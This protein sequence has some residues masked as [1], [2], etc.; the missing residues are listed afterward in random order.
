[1]R[2]RRWIAVLGFALCVWCLTAFGTTEVRAE[3]VG[4]EVD[5]MDVGTVSSGAGWSYDAATNVLTLDGY[6]RT[7]AA[8]DVNGTINADQENLT[9]CLKGENCITLNSDVDMSDPVI[10]GN[11]ITITGDGSYEVVAASDSGD[12]YTGI[13]VCLK[14]LTIQSGTLKLGGLKAVSDLAIEGGMIDVSDQG[15]GLATNNTIRISGGTVRVKTLENRNALFCGQD[16]YIS[17]GTVAVEEGD[18][19]VVGNAYMSGGSAALTGASNVINVPGSMMISGGSMVLTSDM[20]LMN[21]GEKVHITGGTVEL[22]GQN[23]GIYCMGNVCIS[24][25]TVTVTSGNMGIAAEGIEING[26]EYRFLPREGALAA[27]C[28]YTGNYIFGP[29]AKLSGDGFF[30]S[31]VVNGERIVFPTNN[32]ESMNEA[33]EA[34]LNAL[35]AQYG[36]S[37][38]EEL[39]RQTTFVKDKTGLPVQTV[40]DAGGIDI[41]KVNG[42]DLSNGAELTFPAAGITEGDT[43]A[44]LHLTENGVWEH[45]EARAGD[46]VITGVFTSLSPVFYAKVTLEELPYAPEYYEQLQADY[47]AG[48]AAARAAEQA[49]EAQLEQKVGQSEQDTMISPETGDT[50]MP[51]AVGMLVLAAAGILAAGS[52]KKGFIC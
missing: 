40:S 19:F 33:Q 51:A 43:V 8:G 52:R 18:V 38:W 35:Y 47:E 23:A 4:V 3:S 1:M 12:A 37:G 24:A 25:G 41:C 34:A 15:D 26:G 30:A 44:V 45:I 27:V 13:I 14:N 48:Q 49:A 9:I 17:G 16:L 2:V 31:V 46:G 21:V 32:L 39:V 10:Y 20:G 5:G 22:T 36:V 7:H 28:A 50:A 6:V 42:M 11:N 29:N